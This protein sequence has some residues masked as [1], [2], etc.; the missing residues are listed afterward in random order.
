VESGTEE[1]NLSGKEIE[2]GK[3]SNRVILVIV[4]I[5]A[6][7]IIGVLA[8]VFFINGG[9]FG[10][11]QEWYFKGAYANYE[12]STNILFTSVDFSLRLEIVD[13]N[14]T[15]LKTLYDVEL[16]AGMLGQLLDEQN[17]T[18]ISKEQINEI[19]F[20]DLEN[21]TLID[22]HEDQVYLENIGTKDCNVYVY[23]SN[24]SN[25]PMTI[26]LYV[27]KQTDWPIK[28]S[29]NMN[30]EDLAMNLGGMDLGSMGSNILFEIE[31][32]DT[33]IPQLT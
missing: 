7:V 29:V 18:W 33:N 14:G 11:N 26:T 22:T 15:H 32:T 21:Y 16:D 10:R 6:A 1:G 27:D 13:L 2:Q 5:V 4:L 31:L 20:E 3:K 24:D 12:G 23:S 19:E 25:M 9:I 17:T 28:F 8:Y 30:T